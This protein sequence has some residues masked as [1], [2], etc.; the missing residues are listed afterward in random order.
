MSAVSI[1]CACAWEWLA[2]VIMALAHHIGGLAGVVWVAMLLLGMTSVVVYKEAV[3]ES[4]HRLIAISL[5]WLAMSAS[6]IHWLARAHLV[7][8]LMGAG[9]FR[10]LNSVEKKQNTTTLGS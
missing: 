2:D 6:T 7:T 10:G 9:F 4:G 5:T 1:P 8:P 3:A